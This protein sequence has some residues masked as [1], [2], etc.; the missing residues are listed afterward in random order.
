[1]Y[2]NQAGQFLLQ[3]VFGFYIVAVLLRFLLQWARRIF[4]I[5]WCKSWSS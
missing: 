3:V 4:T 5:P 1:M 2:F